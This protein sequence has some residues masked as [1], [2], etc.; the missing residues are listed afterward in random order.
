MNMDIDADWYEDS[1]SD[2]WK[3]QQLQWLID[4]LLLSHG[5][6]IQINV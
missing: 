3:W 6:S 4:S 5:T 1:D 2:Q